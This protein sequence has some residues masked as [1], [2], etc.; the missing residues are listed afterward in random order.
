MIKCNKCS[1]EKDDIQFETYWH[2]N[3]NKHY[4]RKICR[5]CINEQKAK[6]REMVRKEKIMATIASNE[7]IDPFKDQPGYKL[8][9]KC[10]IWKNIE[11]EWYLSNHKHTFPECKICTLETEKIKTEQKR[12]MYLEENCGGNKVRVIPGTYVDEF[13]KD[14]VCSIMNAMGWQLHEENNVW[15][16]EGFK[17]QDAVWLKFNNNKTRT[18][19]N[20]KPE[21]KKHIV[22]TECLQSKLFIENNFSIK[23][24]RINKVC[25][26]CLRIKKSEYQRL[27][28]QKRNNSN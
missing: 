28:H 27:Y 15:W 1:E 10:K 24:T 23:S 14:C 17:T 4:T 25:T 11:T 22:C 5:S 2:K 9:R 19:A 12:Q 3:H 8:C 16:K 18:L 6:Y 13:Q 20:T 21:S 26:E 7:Q